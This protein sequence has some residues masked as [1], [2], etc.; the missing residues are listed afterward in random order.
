MGLMQLK[1]SK[2]S[3]KRLKGTQD[4]GSMEWVQCEK[5]LATVEKFDMKDDLRRAVWAYTAALIERLEDL[6][7]DPVA[8]KASGNPLDAY[9]Y[10]CSRLTVAVEHHMNLLSM[11]GG[12]TVDVPMPT[13][14]GREL[15]SAT[16]DMKPEEIDELLRKAAEWYKN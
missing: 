8:I 4:I 6:L 16:E 10:A 11:L 1:H 13:D 12:G 5:F 15:V 2:G 3:D 7:L 9:K 14:A